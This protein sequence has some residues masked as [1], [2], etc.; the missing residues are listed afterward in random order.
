MRGFVDTLKQQL[1]EAAFFVLS[2]FLGILK[3][4][5]PFIRLFV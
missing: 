3:P 2:N 4:L 1:M 5:L